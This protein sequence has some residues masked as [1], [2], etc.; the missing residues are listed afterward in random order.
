MLL[1]CRLG[2]WMG[3]LTSLLL[4]LLHVI[5]L[6]SFCLYHFLFIARFDKCDYDVPWR[7]FLH[8]SCA[9]DPSCFLDLWLTVSITLGKIVALFF[10]NS[11]GPFLL[12]SPTP[13]FRDFNHTN[14]IP[15][16]V[17]PQL[18]NALFIKKNS[19]FYHILRFL[20]LC[21]QVSLSLLI[22]L[23]WC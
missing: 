11:F 16:E 2:C 17:V 8:A 3:D 22:C 4:V 21:L 14:I 18:T 20:F 10:F 19:L 6:F 1:S 5:C 13:K 12:P 9:R 15:F 23:I 7:G